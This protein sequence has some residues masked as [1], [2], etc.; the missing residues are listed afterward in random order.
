MQNHLNRNSN[1]LLLSH[2]RM[3][4]SVI[5][6][7]EK[8][9]YS[10]YQLITGRKTEFFKVDAYGAENEKDIKEAWNVF[11]LLNGHRAIYYNRRIN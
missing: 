5:S 10:E 8:M 7:T 4:I 11:N 9:F 6:P 1:H 2:D 3:I